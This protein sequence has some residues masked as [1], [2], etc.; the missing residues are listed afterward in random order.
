M[1]ETNT[2]TDVLNLNGLAS[3]SPVL[4]LKLN[5]GNTLDL[6][7]RCAQAGVGSPTI[8]F[9]KDHAVR[10]QLAPIITSYH[11]INQKT[12]GQAKIHLL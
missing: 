10:I 1:Q 9:Q 5:Q 7:K 11:D 6:L 3:T 2:D 12:H 8:T 4:L